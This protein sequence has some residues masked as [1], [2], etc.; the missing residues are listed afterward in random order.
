M[1]SHEGRFQKNI[2][3]K[4]QLFLVTEYEELREDLKTR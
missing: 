3:R 2:E 4:I 1:L